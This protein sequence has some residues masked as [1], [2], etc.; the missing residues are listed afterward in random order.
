MSGSYSLVVVLGLFS[1]VW[2]LAS[3]GFNGWGM[4][5]SCPAV[6]GIFPDQ[7]S[8]S[9]LLHWQADSLPLRHQGSPVIVV[10]IIEMRMTENEIKI[11]NNYEYVI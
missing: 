4:W 3:V 11:K 2:A 10:I 5:L 9:C 1:E 7:G 6:C 8:N